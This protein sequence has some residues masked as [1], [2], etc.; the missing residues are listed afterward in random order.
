MLKVETRRGVSKLAEE[1][2]VDVLS[3]YSWI[4]PILGLTQWFRELSFS[5]LECAS[6][7]YAAPE[8]FQGPSLIRSV[9]VG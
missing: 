8:L 5:R 9:P 7:P 3:F 2:I 4:Q 1:S 6:P